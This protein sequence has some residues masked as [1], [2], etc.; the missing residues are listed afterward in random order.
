MQKSTYLRAIQKNNQK[1]GNSQKN[2]FSK[3]LLVF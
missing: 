3:E 1:Q 2:V